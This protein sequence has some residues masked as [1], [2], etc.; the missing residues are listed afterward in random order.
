MPGTLYCCVPGRRFDGHDFAVQ[1]VAG[2]AVAV[3]S[4][5]RL[6]I[7]VPEVV[8]AS[9]RS[10]LGP[11]AAAL[12][13][14]PGRAMTM[15]GVTGTNGKTTTTHLLA[16]IFRAA[17]HE[18]AVIGTLG[19]TRTTP[20]AP[21]LQARLAECRDRRGRHHRHGG[22][23]PR[24]GRASNRRAGLRRRH[25]HQPDPGPSRLPPAT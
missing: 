16:E 6:D 2:G 22:L 3:L 14:H 24:P 12:Y 11:L 19:G 5:R 25:L 17:G 8:V 10:S 15:I 23:L 9:V 13:G 18:A 4:E 20:E 1:A 21:V 7:G